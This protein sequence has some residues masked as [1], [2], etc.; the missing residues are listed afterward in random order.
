[1]DSIYSGYEK[2]LYDIAIRVTERIR[3]YGDAY[4]DKTGKKLFEHLSW[5]I[6]S[7]E[8]M[9]SKCIEDGLPQDAHSK[10]SAERTAAQTAMS[11]HLLFDCPFRT[12]F[13]NMINCSSDGVSVS[14]A[15]PENLHHESVLMMN[16]SI[17]LRAFLMTES[18]ESCTTNL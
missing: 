13:L 8:S 5:R 11:C 16:T 2:K 10:E 12:V 4:T 14:W 17:S 15:R 18:H 3:N 9:R 1:M 6:K 7:E